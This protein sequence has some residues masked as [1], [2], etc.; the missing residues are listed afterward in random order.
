MMLAT[1]GDYELP[2]IDWV[3]DYSDTVYRSKGVPD[4]DFDPETN[5]EVTWSPNDEQILEYI[6][7]LESLEVGDGLVVCGR[8][9]APLMGAVK[10]VSDGQLT[11]LSVDSPSRVIRWQ[12]G[13]AD[14]KI[15]FARADRDHLFW[16]K[17][18]HVESVEIQGDFK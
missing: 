1:S 10:S 16:N 11:T 5:H 8:G 17:V 15:E 3:S 9:P 18:Y 2:H 4:T 13:I 6:E 14:P 12:S 7:F